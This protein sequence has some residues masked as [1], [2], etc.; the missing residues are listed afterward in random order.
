MLNNCFESN[1]C[2][3]SARHSFEHIFVPNVKINRQ[4]EEDITSDGSDGSDAN[5]SIGHITQPIVV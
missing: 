3:L 5:D 1:V 2:F 4:S